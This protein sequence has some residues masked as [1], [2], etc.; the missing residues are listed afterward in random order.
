MTKAEMR[1]VFMGTPD[2]AEESL[3][4]LYENDFNIVGVFTQPDKPK[5]RGMKLTMSP[6]KELA[7]AHG[8]PVYQPVSM[9]TGEAL[10]ILKELNPDVIAVVAYGKLLPAEIL[11]LPKFGCINIHGSLL[12]KYRGSAPIQWTVLNGDKLAGV[13]AMYM[14]E[15]LDSG[16]MI[17]VS[18]VEVLPDETAGELFDRLAVLGGELLCDTLVSV[19]EGTAARIPQN[20]AEVTFAPPL[21]KDMC[22]IDWNCT[23]D[24]ILNKIRGLNPWPVATTEIQNSVFKVFKAVKA[25]GKGECGKILAADKNG[26]TI[27]CKDGAVCITELQASGGKRMKAADYLRGHPICL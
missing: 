4:A 6:V 22:P 8:T 9:R 20:E 15:G 26:I 1:V 23:M 18:E 7:L 21:K 10:E 16:D 25:S 14:G 2:F 3:K 17:A 12:P 11:D 13:T 5:N 24:E 27:A 19:A